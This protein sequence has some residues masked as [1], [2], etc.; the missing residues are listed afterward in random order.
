MHLSANDIVLTMYFDLQ[1]GNGT[2][3]VGEFMTKKEKLHVVKPTTPVDE[4]I[5]GTWMLFLVDI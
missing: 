4:G 5:F 3:K 1:N 2:Y